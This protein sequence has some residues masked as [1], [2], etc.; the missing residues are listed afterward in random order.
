VI[1]FLPYS[2]QTIDDDDVAQVVRVLMSDYLT[3]GPEVAAFETA[4]AQHVGARYAV[5]VSSGTAALHLA[6]MALDVGAG[7]EVL[8]TPNTFIATSNA[9][10]YCGA[11]PVFADIDENSG[12][13]TSE[14]LK[15]SITEKTKVIAPP[16]IWRLFFHWQ[17]KEVFVWYKTHLI[18]WAQPISIQQSATANTQ[19]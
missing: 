4:L 6:Y 2:R 16:P 13:I 3:Q 17:K 5:A 14:T 10:L 11:T 12:L 9:A 19:I 18:P 8:T 15:N 1:P 7:D